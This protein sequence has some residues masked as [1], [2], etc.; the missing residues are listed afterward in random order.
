MR[1]LLVEDDPHTLRSITLMLASEGYV[2]DTANLGE[3]G[4]EIGKARVH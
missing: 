3:D 2:V 4:L 1:V